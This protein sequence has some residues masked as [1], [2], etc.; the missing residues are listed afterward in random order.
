M[1]YLWLAEDRYAIQGVQVKVTELLFCLVSYFRR[2]QGFGKVHACFQ[3]SV[4]LDGHFFFCAEL[5]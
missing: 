1:R 3:T 2:K 4:C 5:L